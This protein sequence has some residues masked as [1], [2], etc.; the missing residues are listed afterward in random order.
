MDHGGGVGR[1]LL[2]GGG[3]TAV[4]VQSSGRPRTLTEIVVAE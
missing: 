2:E 3:S 1:S 4:A